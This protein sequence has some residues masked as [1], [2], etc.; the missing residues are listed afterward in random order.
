MS[1]WLTLT[2]IEPALIEQVL[3]GRG[4]LVRDSGGDSFAC[5]YRII[6]AVAEG[7]AE[8][9]TGASDWTSVYPGL[10]A[11]VGHGCAVVH[12]RGL[13]D[14]SGFVLTPEEVCRVAEGLVA[15]GW[16]TRSA[17]AW[18]AGRQERG[19]EDLGPF[20]AAAAAEEKAVVGK[21]S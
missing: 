19:L 10:A 8:V 7:R 18:A 16:T 2:K 17:A 6:D 20:F 11:S 15:E 13:G 12:E 9:E 1:T 3:E 5:D 4:P 14:A 21:L